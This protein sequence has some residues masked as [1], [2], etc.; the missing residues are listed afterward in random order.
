VLGQGTQVRRV[1]RQSERHGRPADA[2][3]GGHEGVGIA[4][5]PH[6]DVL[7]RPRSDAR[8]RHQGA[9]ELGRVRP[10]VDH[11]LPA[12]DGLGQGHHG[13]PPAGRHGE[14]T[15]VALGQR[16]ECSR[17]GEEVGHRAERGGQEVAGGEH[18]PSGH[19]ARAGDGHLL[20]DDGAHRQ[21]EA[22]G[23]A[24][25]AASGITP[26]H[27]A[28]ERVLAQRLPDGDG[29]GIEVEQLSAACDRGL[30]VAQIRQDELALHV[31]RA[32]GVIGLRRA[33]GDDA[34]TVRKAQAASV[35]PCGAVEFLD[36]GQGTQPEEVQDRC[37]VEGS[38]AGEA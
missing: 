7:R 16:D 18:Q 17:A 23:R 26:H 22:V 5:R 15:R 36:A 8:E 24:G 32:F 13:A 21:L 10:G 20:P 29:I 14:R 19:R 4:Q 12:V 30:Q 25:D 3:V 28:D 11:D 38:P 31:F 35:G 6:G 2:E 1:V 34:V 27:G 37:R 9:S 33:Q